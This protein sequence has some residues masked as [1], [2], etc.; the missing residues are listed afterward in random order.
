MANFITGIISLTIGVVILA[1]VFI[2]T[3]KDTN[4]T[5]WESSEIAMWGLLTLVAIVG[6]VY[7]V[8]NVF[9]LS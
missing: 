7:G 6:I 1:N 5:T 8:L 4:T 9:G 3:V 2:A